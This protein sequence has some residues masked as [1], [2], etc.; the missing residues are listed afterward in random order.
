MN[1]TG[2]SFWQ[3]VQDFNAMYQLDSPSVPR[4]PTA[5]R[6]SQFKKILQDE[7]NEISGVQLTRDNPSR[8]NADVLVEYADLLGDLVVY[9]TSEAQRHGI[10]LPAVLMVIMDSNM[11]KLGE[12]GQPIIRDGKVQKGPNYWKPEP[13]IADLLRGML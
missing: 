11:S 10:P 1:T 3:R 9:C 12:D 5:E 13:Q 4:A 8:T 2:K 7:V 6:L